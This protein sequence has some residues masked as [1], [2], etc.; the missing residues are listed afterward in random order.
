[1]PFFEDAIL[2]YIVGIE[3]TDALEEISVMFSHTQHF[4]LFQNKSIASAFVEAFLVS[5]EPVLP[6]SQNNGHIA[7]NLLLVLNCRASLTHER[8]QKFLKGIHILGEMLS[9]GLIDFA[10]LDRWPTD[11]LFEF[12]T[13]ELSNSDLSSTDGDRL[14]IESVFPEHPVESLSLCVL[15]VG[16]GG[17][18]VV[19]VESAL[20]HGAIGPELIRDE[21]ILAMYCVFLPLSCLVCNLPSKIW[22]LSSTRTPWPLRW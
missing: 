12:R 21:D 2:N 5:E 15:T 6:Y 13:G 19:S 16:S 11:N 4:V 14:A 20:E 22:E 8:Y 7:R 3:S 17:D 10:I 1:V 18:D 9:Q